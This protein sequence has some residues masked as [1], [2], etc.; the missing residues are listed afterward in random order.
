MRSKK[1]GG[2]WYK[3]EHAHHSR[4]DL[5]VTEGQ[6]SHQNT[7]QLPALT[8]SQMMSFVYLIASSEMVKKQKQPDFNAWLCIQLAVRNRTDYCPRASFFSSVI[9]DE[10]AFIFIAIN[11]Q[12]KLAY[13][14]GRLS[15]A[16]SRTMEGSPVK[17]S[18]G[19]SMSNTSLPSLRPC[20]YFLS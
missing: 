20:R 12:S 2:H 15:T 4:H 3:R 9:W 16:L 13:F 10:P 14:V 1:L 6:C 18:S 5:R 17:K 11:I 7:S 8:Q 19:Q